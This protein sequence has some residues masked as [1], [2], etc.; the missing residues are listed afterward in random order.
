MSKR[1]KRESSK[2]RWISRTNPNVAIDVTQSYRGGY[3]IG[4]RYTTDA[5]GHTSSAPFEATYL[6]LQTNYERETA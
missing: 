6:E 4:Y 5:S 2:G 1:F 3:V